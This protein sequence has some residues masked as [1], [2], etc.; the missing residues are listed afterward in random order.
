M[1]EAFLDALPPDVP[2]RIGELSDYRF[3]DPEAQAAFDELMEHIRE[4]VMGAYFRSMAEGLRSMSPE[5]LARFRDMLAELNQMI[6]QRERGEPYDFE[7]FMQRHGEFFPGNPKTLDELLEQMAARMAA[8]SRLLASMSPE[9]RAELRALSEQVLQDMDLAF[10]VDRLGSNLVLGVPRPGVGGAGARRRRRA[11]AAVGDDRRDGTAARPR[12]ARPLAAGRLPGR[13]DRRRRRGRAAAGARRGRR[14]RPPAAQGDRARVGARRPGL[15][16]TRPARGHPEGCALDGG[17]GAGPGVRAAPARSRGRARGARGRRARRAD[18]RDPAV[19][20]RRLRADRGPAER[21][22]RRR[23]GRPGRAGAARARRPRAAR[24]RAAHRGRDRAAAR[25]LVL[26]AAPR[27][28]RPREADGARAARADRGA[29]PA[30]HA[31]PDR[32]QRLRAPDAAEGARGRRVGSACT[33]RTCTTRSTS[34]VGCSR[35]TRARPAR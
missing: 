5:D 28:R 1:R 13:L 29:L 22:Q 34:R 26:D 23:P 20:V 10:E 6:E 2:G 4:Q 18:R 30:R 24:G 33:G 8:M 27:A 7:G 21:V 14:A 3:V 17:A 32:V 12:G 9:E 11:D 31:V 15:A 35:S 19:A 25:P 16:R